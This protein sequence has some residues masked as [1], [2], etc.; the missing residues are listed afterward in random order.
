MLTNLDERHFRSV[1]LG[2]DLHTRITGKFYT[3]QVICAELADQVA[4][5]LAQRRRPA[6]RRSQNQGAGRLGATL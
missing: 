3:L 1:S 6:P 5:M 4:S 2:K